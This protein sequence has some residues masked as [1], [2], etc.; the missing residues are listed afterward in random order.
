MEIIRAYSNEDYLLNE[1]PIIKNGIRVYY[2]RH[3]CSDGTSSK[4]K[5]RFNQIGGF[6]DCEEVVDN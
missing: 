1:E 5:I 2:F 6:V 4:Y 3:Y